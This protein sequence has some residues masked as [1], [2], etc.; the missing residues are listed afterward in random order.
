M[1]PIPSKSIF[2]NEYQQNQAI[3]I[4]NQINNID[5]LYQDITDTLIE[6]M[7]IPAP[8]SAMMVCYVPQPN[9]TYYCRVNLSEG[10]TYIPTT[11][12]SVGERYFIKNDQNQQN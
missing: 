10:I 8:P 4:N 12:L 9:I 5:S 3:N 6:T 7:N 11:I 2:N 1:S